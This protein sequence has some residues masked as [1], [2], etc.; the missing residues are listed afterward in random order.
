MMIDNKCDESLELER[1]N[2]NLASPDS[3]NDRNYA[4]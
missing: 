4:I 2:E 3:I 1:K